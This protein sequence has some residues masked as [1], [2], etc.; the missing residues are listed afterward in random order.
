MG[1]VIEIADPGDQ[2]LAE[3]LQLTDVARRRR[4]EPELAGTGIFI[5][6][7]EPVVRRA[8]E[9]GYRL[10]S[11]LVDPK[12]LALLDDVVT[13]SSAPTYVAA[14]EILTAVTGFHV[15]RGVLASFARR[16]A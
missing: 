11:L 9:A 10:R 4:V 6:E 2:R 3:Y 13:G 1:D 15:H 8:L 16:P 14:A 12:R 7:G 5:A